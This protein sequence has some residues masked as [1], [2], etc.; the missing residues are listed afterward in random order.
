MNQKFVKW[1]VLVF[2]LIACGFVIT[3]AVWYYFSGRAGVAIQKRL[4]PSIRI[5]SPADGALIISGQAVALGTEVI[6]DAGLS[7]VDF[8]AD[9][10]AAGQYVPKSSGLTTDT[11]AFIWYGVT[12]GWHTLSVVAFDD[13]GR[14]S[15]EVEIQIGV[16][17]DS[18]GEDSDGGQPPAGESGGEPSSGGQEF[19]PPQDQNQPPGQ[20]PQNAQNPDQPDGGDLPELA[21][22]PQDDPPEVTAFRMASSVNAEGVVSVSVFADG[23][24]DLGL[25]RLVLNWQGGGAVPG[26]VGVLCGGVQACQLQHSTVLPPGDWIFSAQAYDTSGQAS[27]PSVRLMQVIE[28]EGLPPAVADEQPEQGHFA[29]WIGENLGGVDF[30]FDP[31]R[32]GVDLGDL[33]RLLPDANPGVQ[34]AGECLTYFVEPLPE[35][36]RHTLTVECDL[37]TEEEGEIL[38]PLVGKFLPNT[39]ISG[40]DLRILE[41][42]DGGRT[43]IPAGQTFTWLD[44]DVTCG[45]LYRYRPHVERIVESGGG[46]VYHGTVAGAEAGVTAHSCASG[47]IGDINLRTESVQGGVSVLWDLNGGDIWPADLPAE[48]VSFN[49]IRFDL[50][51]QQSD[52]LYQ[53][54]IPS[55]VLRS[56]GAYSIVDEGLKC[57]N[58]YQY[59]LTGIAVNADFRLVSPGWLLRAHTLAP[60]LPCPEGSLAG[61]DLQTHPI[62][63]NDRFQAVRIAMQI[64]PAMDF[65]QGGDIELR[66]LRL[67]QGD[68]QCEA[69]P[70]NPFWGV[71]EYIPI[72]DE[73]RRQGLAYTVV[74]HQASKPTATY[75]YRL[76][77]FVDNQ[78]IE[79]GQNAAVTMPKAPPPSPKILRV[80][81]TN[82]C[83]PGVPRCVVVE[84]DPYDNPGPDH[85]YYAQAARIY[86]ERVVGAL[87]SQLFP[88]GM[89][90]TRF[91]DANPY[92]AE[93]HMA[94]GF[95]RQI[96]SFSVV[97][98]MVAYDADGHTFG[99]SP[100]QI[101]TPACDD[102][103][104]VVEETLER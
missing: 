80:T 21:P 64:P 71:K 73:I 57:G 7:R 15:P 83:P 63:I 19:N 38:E 12:P 70:C 10:Q 102:R 39:Y 26:E 49:L 77:L 60:Q 94:D 47:S 53:E 16:V 91:V 56:G 6:A 51:T 27:L 8:L 84:W 36:I 86:V 5:A 99:A 78:E 1:I 44:T 97:Y 40:I 46:Y 17:A 30:D 104:D 48:G 81:A 55:Q 103:W 43:R 54:A 3:G 50:D 98:R 75:V 33:W 90:D 11:P 62:W 68:Q 9:G 45:T 32:P 20:D 58:R 69:S 22:Q 14:P 93:H 61:V 18:T 41:W 85:F 82:T 4:P 100:I 79:S 28:Q 42:A 34:T 67:E 92:M 31:I 89:G 101:Q 13:A 96:C 87:D 88:V 65:P 35:G 29:D 25:T 24:D 95:I 76:G 23:K 74:D 2:L 66:I 72:T 52:L 59:M 37:N